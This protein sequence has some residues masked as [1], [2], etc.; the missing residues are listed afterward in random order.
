MCP[1]TRRYF[2]SCARTSVALRHE[3]CMS[4]CICNKLNSTQ[5][6]KKYLL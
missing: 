1:L 5:P 2:N 4:T 6:C 3:A